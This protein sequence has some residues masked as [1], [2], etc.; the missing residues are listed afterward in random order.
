MAFVFGIEGVPIF[1]MLFVISLLLLIGLIFIL[2]ELRRM[3]A[4]ITKEKS[5]LKRFEEDLKTF[6]NDSGKKS[7]NKLV[8]YVKSAIAKGLTHDKI[9]ESLMLRGWPKEEIDKILAELGK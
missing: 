9:E 5:D 1:E 2:L 6:E 8:D 3:G 7:T 4:L